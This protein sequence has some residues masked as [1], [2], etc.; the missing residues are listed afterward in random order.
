MEKNP[1]LCELTERCPI[2]NGMLIER[3]L[4]KHCTVCGVLCETCCDGGAA[5]FAAPALSS[6]KGETCC[7]GG[8][9]A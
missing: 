2:C 1:P 8:Y 6:S 3:K 9:D 7:D 4:K 5:I